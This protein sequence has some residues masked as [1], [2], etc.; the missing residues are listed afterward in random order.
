MGGTMVEHFYIALADDLYFSDGKG[1]AV[2]A[3]AYA[4]A[5]PNPN[6][7]TDSSYTLDGWFTNCSDPATQPGV[8]PDPR[9]S[10][11]AAL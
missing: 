8:A 10:R 1:N 6:S 3:P 4:I 9:L 2:P 5:N 11:L 7:A